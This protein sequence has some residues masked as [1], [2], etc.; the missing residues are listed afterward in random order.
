MKENLKE[1]ETKMKE[2]ERKWKKIKENERKWEKAKENVIKWSK[3]EQDN[4]RKWQKMKQQGKK[5]KERVPKG[6]PPETKIQE[7]ERNFT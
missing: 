6:V 1:N 7:I 3:N 4:E 2:T 5:M